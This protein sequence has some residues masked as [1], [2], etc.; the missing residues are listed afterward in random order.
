MKDE[1]AL[2]DDPRAQLCE[3]DMIPHIPGKC[4]R[5]GNVMCITMPIEHRDRRFIVD[6]GSGHD[7]ISVEKVETMDLNTYDT[8]KINFHTVN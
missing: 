4:G 6:S 3:D 5:K 2:E 7:L 8:D 1:D